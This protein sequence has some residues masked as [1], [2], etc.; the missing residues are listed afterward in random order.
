MPFALVAY[1]VWIQLEQLSPL[2]AQ[3]CREPALGVAVDSELQH[4]RV[5]RM[6][7]TKEVLQ[8]NLRSYT[9]IYDVHAYV[10]SSYIPAS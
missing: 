5:M 6:L 3:L 2:L 7:S 4:F 10:G 9:T 8:T 1:S